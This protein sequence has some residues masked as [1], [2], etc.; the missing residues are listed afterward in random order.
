MSVKTKRAIC[1][2]LGLLGFLVMLGIIGGIE[3][4][5]V[6]LG[7]GLMMCAGALGISAGA[8]WKGGWLR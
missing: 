2:W 1:G 8:L 7:R 5:G 6:P 3:R 4:L